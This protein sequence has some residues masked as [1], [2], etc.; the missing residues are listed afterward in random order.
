M[1]EVVPIAAMCSNALN[2][3]DPFHI[4]KHLNEALDQVRRG[5]QSSL[6]TKQ[7]RAHL[8]E[9][10]CPPSLARRQVSFTIWDG[11]GVE[12]EV[13]PALWGFGCLSQTMTASLSFFFSTFQIDL[14]SRRP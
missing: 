14:L 13:A 2:V 10:V 9:R 8:R 12:G 6:R 7:E 1:V 4:A 11:S 3:L 5:E